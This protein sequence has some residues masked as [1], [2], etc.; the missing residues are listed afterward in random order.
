MNDLDSLS[1]QIAKRQRAIARFEAKAVRCNLA[2]DLGRAVATRADDSAKYHRKQLEKL[3]ELQ[4]QLSDRDDLR[5]QDAELTVAPLATDEIFG[6]K[7][8]R[9][10]PAE[11]EASYP[12]P[13]G[14][15]YRATDCPII[16]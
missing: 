15:S 11:S 14:S 12:V 8:L 13:S 3:Q 1:K 9:D 7:D 4:K 2:T 5:V 16:G 6:T 10:D